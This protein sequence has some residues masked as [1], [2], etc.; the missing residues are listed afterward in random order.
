MFEN[1]KTHNMKKKTLAPEPPYHPQ[2]AYSA[3][4]AGPGLEAEGF[5]LFTQR[6]SPSLPSAPWPFRPATHTRTINNLKQPPRR[7][8]VRGTLERAKESMGRPWIR[9]HLPSRHDTGNEKIRPSG[10]PYEPS[11]STPIDTYSPYA[12]T[13]AKTT[14]QSAPE[15]ATKRAVVRTGWVP[16]IQSRV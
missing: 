7:L 2:A 5:A 6:R 1:D 16:R 14:H 13:G 3:V 8:R 10:T 4:W 11:D 12:G 9:V 15:A